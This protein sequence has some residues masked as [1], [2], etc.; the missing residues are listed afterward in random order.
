MFAFALWDKENQTLQLVRDRVG[1]KP[2]Y[3][4]W[5]KDIFFFASELKSIKKYPHFERRISNEALSFQLKF[6]TYQ[7]HIQFMKMFIN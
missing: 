5:Q 1:E 4:G 6:E 7:R 2:L 3:Y